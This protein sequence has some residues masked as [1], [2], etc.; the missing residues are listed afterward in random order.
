MA[1]VQARG[2]EHSFDFCI[3]CKC[4]LLPVTLFS[5]QLAC[6]LIYIGIT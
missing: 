4:L 1:R 3:H 5:R 2:D 6:L